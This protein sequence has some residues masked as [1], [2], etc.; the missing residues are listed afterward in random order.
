MM[1]PAGR[2]PARRFGRAGQQA[3]IGQQLRQS[4]APQSTPEIPKEIAAR[5][6][7]RCRLQSG[8]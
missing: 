5:P 3:A 8:G 1:D 2:L 6:A 4:Y 7:Q